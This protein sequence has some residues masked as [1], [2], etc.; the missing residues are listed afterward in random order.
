MLQL[1]VRSDAPTP[2]GS[3]NIQLEAVQSGLD[4]SIARCRSTSLHV[5]GAACNRA[6]PPSACCLASLR[7]RTSQCLA[8][9]HEQQQTPMHQNGKH[10]YSWD[11][12]T[13]ACCAVSESSQA[14][15][16]SGPGTPGTRG[17]HPH[18]CGTLTPTTGEPQYL[19][20]NRRNDITVCQAA[21]PGTASSKV[22]ALRH[23]GTSVPVGSARRVEESGQH[24]ASTDLPQRLMARL[25]SHVQG[26]SSSDLL[27]ATGRLC[28]A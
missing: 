9:Q 2:P 3:Y 12:Q 17:C 15:S 20:I 22:Q 18:R 23:I 6:P 7:M 21:I 10:A 27:L 1:R 19:T 16:I 4:G 25:T 24:R 8:H 28:L 13:E 14:D 5:I 26:S 11:P